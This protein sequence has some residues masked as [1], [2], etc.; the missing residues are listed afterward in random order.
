MYK[1]GKKIF[2]MVL[3]VTLVLSMLT[4]CGKGEEKSTPAPT[5]SFVPFTEANVNYKDYVKLGEYKKITITKDIA[6]TE[7]E[8]LTMLYSQNIERDRSR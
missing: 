4:G 5:T 7:E 3:C 1:K 6:V 2:V 8:I